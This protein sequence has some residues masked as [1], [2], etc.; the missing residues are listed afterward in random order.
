MF[1]L[2]LAKIQICKRWIHNCTC[3]VV[4]VLRC[5]IRFFFITAQ[6]PRNMKK[7]ILRWH[8]WWHYSGFQ[9]SSNGRIIHALQKLGYIV[10]CY[11]SISRRWVFVFRFWRHLFLHCIFWTITKQ[12]MSRHVCVRLQEPMSI[13]V[14]P[15]MDLFHIAAVVSLLLHMSSHVYPLIPGKI[16]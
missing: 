14:L 12:G 15:L 13:A 6:D 4:V 3:V 1:I 7:I 5:C 10:R 11:G 8:W 2:Y 9:K 16:F